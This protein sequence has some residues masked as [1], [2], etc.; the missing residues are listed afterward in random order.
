[1]TALPGREPAT[2]GDLWS[3]QEALQ[4]E[5]SEV[6]AGLD[7]TARLAPLGPVLLAG[8][9]V[10]GLMC[11]RDLDVMVHVGP[12]FSKHD[13]LSLVRDFIGRPDVIGF[14][15]RDERGARSPTGTK[16]DERYHVVILVV[17][18]GQTWRIDVTLW[19][20][21]PHEN[22]TAWHEAL[23]DRTTDEQRAAVL[24]IKDVWHRSPLYPDLIGGYEIYTAVMDDGV[25]TP[26]QFAT[27]LADHGHPV[28]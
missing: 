17:R 7:L 23:R 10:S 3:R 4:A 6:L 21:D 15:Y 2:D 20:N 13:V 8:S 24:R 26:Q 14:D 9:Y 16:R 19:L 28:A 1:M 12:R 22:V 25:R 18:D 27:W 11:W 5:A